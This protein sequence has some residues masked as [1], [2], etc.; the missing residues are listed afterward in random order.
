MPHLPFRIPVFAPPLSLAFASMLAAGS[1]SLQPAA[2]GPVAAVFPPWWDGT[3][4]LLAAA[5]AGA[6][7]RFGA[8][9]CIVVVV[10][11]NTAQRA[12]LWRDGAWALVN[13]AAF[14]GC[15][16]RK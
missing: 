15:G 13:P 11:E 10:P 8:L 14:G 4:A 1:I 3:R 12:Q 2:S 9:P 6:V 7:V 16:S 5:P